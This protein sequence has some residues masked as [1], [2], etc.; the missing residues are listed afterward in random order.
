MRIF[1]IISYS[2]PIVCRVCSRPQACTQATRA[3]DWY[4]L[5]S[6]SIVCWLRHTVLFETEESAQTAIAPFHQV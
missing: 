4:R 6:V 5:H 3:Y 1:K 2:P